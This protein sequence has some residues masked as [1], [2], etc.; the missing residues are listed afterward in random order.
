[1]KQVLVLIKHNLNRIIIRNPISF[2]VSIV[3]PVAIAVIFI[4][5]SSS[6]FDN[7]LKIG[8]VDKDSSKSSEYLINT[9]EENKNNRISYYDSYDEEILKGKKE[10]IIIEIKDG[11][12]ENLAKENMVKTSFLDG[13]GQGDVINES[14]TSEI[15]NLIKLKAKSNGD[16]EEY[17]K[18]I[19]N[20]LNYKIG[21][22][23]ENKDTTKWAEVGV[24]VMIAQIIF[25]MFIRGGSVSEIFFNDKEINIFARLFTMPIKTSHYHLALLGSSIVA[26]NIQS[27]ATILIGKYI[28]NVNFGMPLWRIFLLM[29]MISTVII[30]FSQLLTTVC[31][32]PQEVGNIN[33]N[34]LMLWSIIGGAFL[35]VAFFPEVLNKISFISPIRWAVKYVVDVQGG[36]NIL[37]GFESL[38]I[39]LLFATVMF[40]S[41]VYISNRKEK[42]YS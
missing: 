37:R 19:S 41:A 13:H 9:I 7:R 32:T 16:E 20:Q 25:L 4:N 15:N 22:S 2:I 27:I 3:A 39:I 21:V 8:I 38:S 23:V 26:L 29:F 35:P 6:S 34:I 30:S 10:S 12:E 18:L 42:S 17:S 24:Q 1:M 28:L 40:L 36:I 5:M 14:I 33:M 31:K 11:F